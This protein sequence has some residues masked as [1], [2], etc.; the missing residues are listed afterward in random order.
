MSMDPEVESAG[1]EAAA[2]EH[3]HQFKKAADAYKKAIAAAGTADPVLVGMLHI[4]LGNAERSA[5]LSDKA[6]A[7]YQ[8]ATELLAGQKGEAFLQR[9]YAF[10]HIA[11]QLY[12]KN[13]P[14]AVAA[15]NESLKI[16]RAYPYTT[17][18]DL[19]DAVALH[20]VACLFLEKRCSESDFRATWNDVKAAPCSGLARS[21]AFEFVSNYLLF[22]KQ[23]R[24]EEYAKARAEVEEWALPDFFA[25]TMAV[26]ERDRHAHK[27]I[28]LKQR[29]Q[30]AIFGIPDDYQG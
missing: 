7:S 3:R 22:I 20:F 23:T 29:L 26:V 25:E 19:A 18:T 28:S 15:A 9:G 24:P 11:F 10:L 14:Q 21:I 30:R 2:F 4:N 13:D 27:A 6:I 12:C 17:T 1:I 5:G 16:H 8:R